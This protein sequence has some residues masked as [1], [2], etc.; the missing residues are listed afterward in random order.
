MKKT[1][2]LILT[3]FCVIT[4]GSKA[5]NGLN[6]NNSIDHTS[7]SIGV[8]MD[9]GGFGGKFLVYPQ[10]NFGLFVGAGY[11]IA[12][13]GINCGFKVRLI[14]EK[15]QSKI[16]PYLIGM[17]GYNAAIAV[18]NAD[19]YN[20]LFYGPTFG[21]GLDFRPNPESI[22]YWSFALLLPIRS[23]EVNNYIDDLKNNHGVE[24]KNGLVP[25]GISFGYRFI[26]N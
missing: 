9:H 12:G 7:I 14:N 8:G 4:N 6:S 26:L 1:V 13:F 20:K 25:I 10:N 24:F 2:F 22:G 21:I 16:S 11:A 18:T 5:T 19:Q 23:S 15:K 17:Y 3:L